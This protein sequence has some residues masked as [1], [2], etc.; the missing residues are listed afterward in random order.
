VSSPAIKTHQDAIEHV[1]WSGR[2]RPARR[3]AAEHGQ[4]L[5]LFPPPSHTQYLVLRV[6]SGS[7]IVSGRQVSYSVPSW[8][9]TESKYV[10]SVQRPVE[11][12]AD[13]RSVSYNAH[14]ASIADSPRSFQAFEEALGMAAQTGDESAYLRIA[15]LIDWSLCSSADFV[16]AVRLALTAGAHLFARDLAA[17]GTR[18]YPEHLELQKMA[19]VLAPP[20]VVDADIP[21]TP[22]VRATQDWLRDHA[23]EHKGQWVALREGTLLAT[24]TTASEVWNRLESTDGVMLTRVI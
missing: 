1:M 9:V 16:R 3:V 23:G 13:E 17:Q 10:Y 20:R 2:K 5:R 22:S 21:P 4:P 18:L 12:S 11:E 8:P 7:C 15:G 24:G 19:H 14:H 6:T